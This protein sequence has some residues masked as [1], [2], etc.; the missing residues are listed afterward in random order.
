MDYQT[1]KIS[2]QGV[3]QRIQLYR[4]EANNSINSQLT[5]ELLSAL[6][7]AEAEEVVK[8]IILEGLPDVFCTGM[9]FGEVATAQEL[10][11]KGRYNAYYDILKQMSQSSKVIL[12]V[13]RGKVQ[14]GGVGLVAASDL[15]IADETATFVLSELLFG[16]LP[17]CVLPFLIRR[18]GFQKAYRLA[19]TTQTISASEAEKWGL[20]D[21]YGSST[22]QLIS[23]YIRRLKYLPSSGVKELKNYISQLWIV[24]AETQDLAVNEIFRLI[25]EPTVQE[26]IKRFQQEGLFPWQT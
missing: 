23:K 8:V 5:I 22:N 26:K 4:P 13:V 17:A 6:Q 19:L 14:A 12:S 16:L 10:D 25:T 11:P 21:E 18:V 2:D 9:D 24:Q 3:V 1:L 15:V 7:A 20:I